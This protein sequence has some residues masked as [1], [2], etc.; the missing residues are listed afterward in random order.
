MEHTIQAD[1][2]K[3]EFYP[4]HFDRDSFVNEEFLVPILI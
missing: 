3:I 4:N 1:S 2:L